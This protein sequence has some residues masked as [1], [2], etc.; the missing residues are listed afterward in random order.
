MPL[1]ILPDLIIEE[2]KKICY[3]FC[4]FAFDFYVQV[5]YFLLLLIV[6]LYLS[7]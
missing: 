1:K 5:A 6:L 7:C 4:N 3:I 2:R